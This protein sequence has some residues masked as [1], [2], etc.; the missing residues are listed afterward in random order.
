MPARDYRT[1][2]F[3][4]ETLPGGLS[5][6]PRLEGDERVD[7]AIVGA[8]YTG[9][10]TAYYLKALRPDL[11]VALLD[12]AIAG[13]GASGRN[14][15]WCLGATTGIEALLRDPEQRQRG[16]E[17]QRAL[18]ETVDEIGRVC[19]QEGIECDFAKGGSLQIATAPAHRATFRSHLEALRAAGLGE[20]DYR[21]LEPDE[22]TARIRTRSNL[23]ALFTPHCAA[24][25]PARLA[26]G[27]AAAVE[28]AGAAIYEESPVRALE[29]RGVR[30]PHGRLR[31]DLVV[32][33][34]EA[35]TRSLPGRRRRLLPVHSLMIATEPLPEQT[36]KEIGLERR[37]TF[38]DGRRMVTYGQR[39]R[40]GRIAFGARAR[41]YFGSRIRNRLPPDHGAF[42]RVREILTSL[43]PALSD[44]PI[45]HAWGGA[46]GVPRDWR[47][48]V[49]VER[50]RGLAWGGGYVGEG[51]APSN[52]VGRTLA[53]LILERDTPL[54]RLPWV[55]PYFENWEPEPLRWLA[56]GGIRLIGDWLDRVE[57][58]SGRPSGV[59]R[60]LYRSLVRR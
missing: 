57:L 21:W 55:R 49:G 31:A 36:W 59:A 18:F 50:E 19:E 5:P 25:H 30:T 33:A 41:Y 24:L 38:G 9:L 6:R 53:D 39:T 40:D 2:S 35:Y 1:E 44:T 34:T 45:T 22:C 56:F 46:L 14:G 11:R 16:L 47:V 17:L 29:E 58:G 60:R 54:A 42:A 12:A 27:L 28:S 8:G 3:W 32:I 52:L 51:V 37:E 13:A 26:R 15:G 23:G 20:E 48:S 10:W 4:L 43:F 7:V